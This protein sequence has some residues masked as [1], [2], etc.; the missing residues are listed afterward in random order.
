MSP[1]YFQYRHC[2]I[3]CVLV[4]LSSVN[5]QWCAGSPVV[6]LARVDCTQPFPTPFYFS[7]DRGEA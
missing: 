5:I 4:M 2:D 7:V 3:V 6:L 1:I